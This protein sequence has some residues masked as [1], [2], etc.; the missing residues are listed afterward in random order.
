MRVVP[1]GKH[2]F[3]PHLMRVQLLFLFIVLNCLLGSLKAQNAEIKGF[4]YN[5]KNGE[6]LTGVR[7]S[8]KGT[9]RVQYTD[10]DGFYSFPK[11]DGK[12][13]DLAAEFIGYDSIT[14]TLDLSK[15]AIIKE[16]FYLTN[17]RLGTVKIQVK[18]RV[19][20]DGSPVR[21]VEG[22]KILEMP[23][24]GSEP[25]LVQYLQTLPGVVFSGD[26]GGQLYIR[27]GSPV[28]NKIM[29]DGLPIYN[30]FHSIGLFSVFDVDLIKDAE[31]YT[32][33]FGAEHG[34]RI[35]AV[36]DVHTRDGNTNKF[37]GKIRASTFASKLLLEGPLKKFEKRES[38]SSFA[39]SYRNSYLR[40]SSKVFYPFIEERKLP[41]N[42][43]D[44]FAKLTMNSNSGGYLK[45]FGFSFGDN[46]KFPGS[47]EYNWNNVGLGGRFLL[48]PQYSKTQM[49]G[50]FMY[51]K[52]NINQIELDNLPRNSGIGGISFGLNFA[53]N[54][55][56][57]KIRWGIDVNGFETDFSFFNP[58][59]RKVEQKE[60]TTELNG[61]AKYNF[62][63]KR[64]FG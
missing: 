7:M 22:K 42:F 1:F 33:G 6:R 4:V 51:S 48:V 64:F 54:L 34:G 21:I 37:A 47:T 5:G 63:R 19:E 40:N 39:I 20:I 14:K 41:Y 29:L 9:E 59:D 13:Y 43:G 17:Q 56:K 46:V 12:R 31:V 16:D 58:N 61:Y 35:G 32:S 52:Y 38:N 27:G 15:E 11:L 55:K 3:A 49:D 23:S 25:D 10:K 2:I 50:F 30:P 44:L 24:V 18:K 57:D 36:I 53:Y 60:S 26:Q 62:K 28:M 45:L 8:L